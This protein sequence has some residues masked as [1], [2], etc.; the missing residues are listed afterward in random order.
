MQTTISNT[1]APKPSSTTN[2]RTTCADT[3]K[4]TSEACLRTPARLKN[5]LRGYLP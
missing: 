3:V 5:N 4:D 1:D 2:H